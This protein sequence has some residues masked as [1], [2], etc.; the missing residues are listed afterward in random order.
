M[1][2]FA[3]ICAS[4]LA[5]S[6]GNPSFAAQQ[7]TAMNSTTESQQIHVTAEQ[8][9]KFEGMY[10]L[11]PN[12]VVTFF[13]KEGKFLTQAPGQNS[14]EIFADSANTFYAK[15]ADIKIAFTIGADGFASH[16]TFTQNG[17]SMPTAPR[18]VD[19]KALAAL[20]QNRPQEDAIEKSKPNYTSSEVR[21]TNPKAQIE[22]A[23]TMTIPQGSGPFPTVVLVH[24]SGPNNRNEEVHKHKVFLVLADHLSK[25]GI[26]V[27]RYDKRGIAAS[28]GDYKSATTSDF[29]QDTEAALAYL[30][31]R[32]DVDQTKLGII[33]HSEGGM[34]APIVAARDPHLKFIVLMGAPGI[35][36]KSLMLEQSRLL[37]QAKGESKEDIA[38]NEAS[39]KQIYTIM[40]SGVNDKTIDSQISALFEQLVTDGKIPKD[41]AK[42]QVNQLSNAWFRHFI[43]YDPTPTLKQLKQAVLAINGELDMQVGAKSNLSGLREALKH[44]KKT[45]IQELPKLNHLFQTA[46]TGSPSEY[47]KIEETIAPLALNIISDWIRQQ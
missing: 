9:K 44:N 38:E 40:A 19:A 30:R 4:A 43:K 42:A 3:I 7:T 41:V 29:A 25:Q 17:K 46:N 33:G 20:Q 28:K 6:T 37:A 10:Q 26:A 18:I 39:L 11:A 22:L 47:G 21:F 8:F 1:Q 34:I 14:F 31:T 35:S 16:F 12:V 32:K 36:I 2:K 24:G 45:V 5:L 15:V 23:G 13:Q 27:L